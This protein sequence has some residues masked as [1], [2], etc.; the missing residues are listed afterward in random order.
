MYIQISPGV[1]N[2][3]TIINVMSFQKVLL[4]HT[5]QNYRHVAFIL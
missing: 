3:T 2:Q 1:I 4:V 5:V